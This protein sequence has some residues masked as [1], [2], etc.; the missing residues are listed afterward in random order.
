[1]ETN[2]RSFDLSR[3]VID[4][5][6]LAGTSIVAGTILAGNFPLYHGVVLALS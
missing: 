6:I 3:L 5:E 2:V 1:M 4:L